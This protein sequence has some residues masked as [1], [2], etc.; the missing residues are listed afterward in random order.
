MVLRGNPW[1]A[2]LAYNMFQVASCGGFGAIA[3]ALVTQWTGIDFVWWEPAVLAWLLVGVLGVLDVSV[4]AK[5]LA[6]MARLELVCPNLSKHCAQ[7]RLFWAAD[8]SV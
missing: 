5:V 8:V 2:L 4:N 6:A 7:S 1:V 3:S